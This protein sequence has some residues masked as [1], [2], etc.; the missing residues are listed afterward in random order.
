MHCALTDSWNHWLRQLPDD[1]TD[2]YFSEGYVRLYENKTTNAVCFVAQEGQQLL[3]LPFLKSEVPGCPGL[4]D[5][6]T[7][8]G[9]GGPISNTYNNS[10][11]KKA[12]KAFLNILKNNG[13]IAGLIRFH[14]LLKNHNLLT[15]VL[16]PEY[17][18]KTV[19]VP[20][21]LPTKEIW[22]LHMH[23]K[24]RKAVRIADEQHHCKY[25]ADFNWHYMD[26][27]IDIY[28]ETMVSLDANEFFMFDRNYF[29]QL[30]SKLRNNAFLGV[31]LHNDNLVAGC[32]FLY[33]GFYANTH[34]SGSKKES[35]AM[36]PNNYLLYMAEETLKELGVKKY[37]LGGGFDSDP[38]N[39]LF[40]YKSQFSKETLS[41][42]IGK[43]ISDRSNY[44]KVCQRWEKETNENMMIY[45]KLHL[46]YRY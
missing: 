7:A 12:G 42:Y 31:V 38:N 30:K 6:E 32:I 36:R 13:I 26:S 10:F 34:L 15:D 41:F 19:C 43:V 18:R 27:F 44:M 28:H 4:Y 45:N 17:N 1:N 24:N 20:L 35:L 16:P 22:E 5:F 33:Q 23:R 14:P 9:Y 11:H 2:I 29:E 37:H 25:I 39:S 40:L 3:L 8:Y 21:D 46:K